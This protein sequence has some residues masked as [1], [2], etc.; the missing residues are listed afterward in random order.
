M[1]KLIFSVRPLVVLSFLLL[2]ACGGAGGDTSP[3]A[4]YPKTGWYQPP[5]ASDD[6]VAAPLT[7]TSL[8]LL[9]ERTRDRLLTVLPAKDSPYVVW[10]VYGLRDVSS[11]SSPVVATHLFVLDQTRRAVLRVSL[12]ANGSR[13]SSSTLYASDELCPLGSVAQS[14]A[15]PTDS[16]LF[17]QKQ[18][19]D[20]QCGTSDDTAVVLGVTGRT[21]E[22]TSS[23]EVLAPINAYALRGDS[24]WLIRRAG[25]ASDQIVQLRAG[26]PNTIAASWN[27]ARGSKLLDISQNI[28]LF[29]RGATGASAAGFTRIKLADGQVDVLTTTLG[30]LGPGSSPLTFNGANSGEFTFV[31]SEAL[32][33]GLWR[34]VLVKLPHDKATGV[35]V[36]S[37][38]PFSAADE[39]PSGSIP[40]GDGAAPEYLGVAHPFFADVYL[41][42]RD[43]GQL[44]KQ[45]TLSGQRAIAAANNS[46]VFSRVSVDPKVGSDFSAVF[47]GSTIKLAEQFFLHALAIGRDTRSETRTTEY[48]YGLIRV[49]TSV[50]GE[51]LYA[52]DP[53]KSSL[54]LYA[55]ETAIATAAKLSS[56]TSPVAPKMLL[57]GSAGLLQVSGLDASTG[58]EKSVLLSFDVGQ[59]DSWIIVQTD[60]SQ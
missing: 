12:E 8:E 11:S 53:Y 39:D 40:L 56:L 37:L 14:L 21:T 49:R 35:V 23:G 20:K 58:R 4:Q 17:I 16:V 57:S 22:V 36:A 32:A 34:R 51:R 52:F 26:A 24:G 42:D 9:H 38:S 28:A 48:G 50:G 54:S 2:A 55:D 59:K 44:V 18:G 43:R 25:V 7:V 33:S 41:A 46:L 47:Q 3:E 5:V 29:D 60:S 6:M 19:P 30:I 31:G 10:P 27:V 15:Q 1:H 13:P 45:P